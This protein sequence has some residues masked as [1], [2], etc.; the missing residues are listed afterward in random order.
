MMI[1]TW[2]AA[3]MRGECPGAALP[4]CQ[5][6][7]EI[8]GVANEEGVVALVYER[9]N[10]PELA[11]A[12]PPELL[13]LFADAARVKAAES[14]FREAECGRLLERL[15]K[16]DLPVLL[17]KGSALAYGLYA[18]PYLRECSDIDLL[19]STRAAAE[20]ACA[21][22][23]EAGRYQPGIAE[24]LGTY[25]L[26]CTRTRN[27]PASLEVDLHW[28]IGSSPVYAD[29]FGFDELFKASLALPSLAPTARGLGFVQAYLH[30]SMHR[31]L[32]LWVGV[33][34]RLKWLYDLHLMGQQFTEG[35]WA[36]LVSVCREKQ[37]C[38]PALDS[39]EAA[40]ATFH[41]SIPEGVCGP[42]RQGAHTEPIDM[43]R[44]R[45]WT[46]IQML[47]F[48]AMPGLS[49]KAR[50]LGQ[51]LFPSGNFL[52]HYYG[53]GQGRVATLSRHLKKGLYRLRG[54]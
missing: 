12:I 47:N 23:C 26:T 37:L 52:Q 5:G 45:H 50:W 34:D 22:L 49:L 42:L 15:E 38:G 39:L 6:W 13:G 17:L 3:V 41:T 16:E 48:R 2:L 51:R 14:M 31:V 36:E 32:N 11:A 25:E 30:A 4:D 21:A 7:S 18:A 27:S 28:G 1:R 53:N 10:N 43:Q 44:I 29:R 8:L 35:E 20:Q 54:G 24:K 40:A 19:F 46:Y 33:G 9:M